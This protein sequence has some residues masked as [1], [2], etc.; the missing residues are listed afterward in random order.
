MAAK[1]GSTLLTAAALVLASTL[2]GCGGSGSSVSN[3]NTNGGVTSAVPTGRVVVTFRWPDEQSVPSADT[4][5]TRA[6]PRR[7]RS[8]LVEVLQAGTVIQRQERQR[9]EGNGGQVET[10][11]FPNV[12]KRGD[13]TIR[14][15]AFEGATSSSVA[16]ATAG[17]KP[18]GAQDFSNGVNLRLDSTVTSLK[19][20][21]LATSPGED[22][23]KPVLTVG[24][25]RTVAITPIARIEGKDYVILLDPATEIQFTVGNNTR[26]IEVA[27]SASALELSIRAVQRT[28]QPIPISVT[29]S[30]PTVVPVPPASINVTVRSRVAFSE[31][32]QGLVT[33]TPGS[34]GRIEGRRLGDAVSFKVQTDAG[35][36]APPKV[37]FSVE[38]TTTKPPKPIVPVADVLSGV[39]SDGIANSGTTVTFQ[40]GKGAARI[41]GTYRITAQEIKE[42][43][44]IQANAGTT[45]LEIVVS[46]GGY[47]IVAPPEILRGGAELITANI[48]GANPGKVRFKVTRQSD[49]ADVTGSVLTSNDGDDN[50]VIFSSPLEDTVLSSGN[51]DVHLLDLDGKSIGNPDPKD[52]ENRNKDILVKIA[53]NIPSIQVTITPEGTNG[54]FPMTTRTQQFKATVTGAAVVKVE[55]W[56]F[57]PGSLPSG[58]FKKDNAITLGGEITSD[59]VYTAP[60]QLP[61][62]TDVL[63]LGS[64]GKISIKVDVTVSKVGTNTTIPGSLLVSKTLEIQPKT[65]DVMGTVQ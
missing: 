4:T 62:A 48:N 65:S 57:A 15:T 60:Y 63:P 21:V 12:P 36:G 37:K 19:A 20:E 28:D 3:G 58:L 53:V 1:T 6:I 42:D 54:V 61:A 16:M 30:V 13:I 10:L 22:S 41:G 45:S 64:N 11:E 40:S 34:E 9:P 43:G 59:G 26:N 2:T 52:P 27:K 38:E 50:Q 17:P 24:E 39:S 29:I 25:T 56:S 35:S 44:T 14:A 18:I 55:G 47:Q 31:F 23:T 49:G 32:Q 7:A 33:L 8:L 51:Y 5:A 46:A